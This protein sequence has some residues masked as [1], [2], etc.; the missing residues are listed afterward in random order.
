VCNLGGE[1]QGGGNG[2]VVW[3]SGQGSELGWSRN[4]QELLATGPGGKR[5]CYEILA[6]VFS[7]LK[8]PS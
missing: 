1:G 5:L 7:H 8:S 3:G 2:S 4:S 6:P